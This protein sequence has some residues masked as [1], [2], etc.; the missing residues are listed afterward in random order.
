LSDSVTIYALTDPDSG[1]VRY[2]GRTTNNLWQRYSQHLMGVSKATKPWVQALRPLQKVPSLKI[3]EEGVSV[4]GAGVRERY[5][6]SYWLEQGASLL[7]YFHTPKP[8]SL[9]PSVIPGARGSLRALSQQHG[10]LSI[11]ELTRR[12]G[13]SRQVGWNLWHGYTGIGRKMLPILHDGLG[14]PYE[15]LLQV[16]PIPHSQRPRRKKPPEGGA[17]A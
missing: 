8:H 1:E 7:N 2:V 9:Q 15:E 17:G 14:I 6:I 3:L 12:T 4:E 11:R 10:I 16:D 5:W 13:L